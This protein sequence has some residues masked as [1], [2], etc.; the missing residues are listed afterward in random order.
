MKRRILIF[1]FIAVI[2]AV[3]AGCSSEGATWLED[4]QTLEVIDNTLGEGEKNNVR[5]VHT[6]KNSVV[7]EAKGYIYILPVNENNPTVRYFASLK[8]DTK[9]ELI[10]I[11][12]I[13][14]GD[15][16]SADMFL[17][18]V[19]SDMWGQGMQLADGTN[20][21]VHYSNV[22]T[23]IKYCYKVTRN[24]NLTVWGF[25]YLSVTITSPLVSSKPFS[26]TIDEIEFYKLPLLLS[27]NGDSWEIK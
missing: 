21:T 3:F 15:N 2:V 26:F 13:K 4:G 1:L 18:S 25:K 12:N 17:T 6:Y 7:N 9:S 10:E 27:H 20:Q 8:Q 19:W 24:N 14:E 11:T 5:F 16:I 22:E 23:T